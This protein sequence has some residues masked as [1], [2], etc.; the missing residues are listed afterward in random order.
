[1]G[2]PFKRSLSGA[3]DSGWEAPGFS[4]A[5]RHPGPHGLC[6]L[7]KKNARV[8]VAFRP[9]PK[10]LFCYSERTLAREGYGFRLLHRPL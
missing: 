1:M 3:F 7:R 5:K 9:A 2:A 10:F 6:S 8:E 4:L